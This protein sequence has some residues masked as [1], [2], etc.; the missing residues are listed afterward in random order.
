ME[1][2]QELPR[3]NSTRNLVL[4]PCNPEDGFENYLFYKIIKNKSP[5]YLHHLIPK[6]LTPYSTRNSENLPPIK[7]NHSFLKST[8]FPS[9]I[10]EWNKLDS[11]IRCSPS[12]KLFRKQIL[13][14]NIFNVPNSLDL[15]YLTRL[16]VG[17]SYLHEHK[18]RHNFQNS[19]NS[20]CNCGNA[21]ESTKHY[22][23]HC[24]NFKN[25]RQT[26]L[27]N[28]RIVNP[29][30]LSINEDVLTH[31]LLYGD[32]S[33]TDNTNTFLLNSVIEYITSA[34]RFNNPLIL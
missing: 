29:N 27:Q 3:K 22:L 20:I 14:F 25:E 32:V 8:F 21:I 4:S 11:N 7:A 24:L 10:I 18:F 5:S 30:L 9:T 15:T 28:V 16:C 13:E 26:V 1:L 33:L 34:E 6:P 19:L 17:S 2:L 31:L 23:L 12:Y